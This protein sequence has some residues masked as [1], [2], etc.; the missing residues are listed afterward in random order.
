MANEITSVCAPS[1]GSLIGRIAPVG[2][3]APDGTYVLALGADRS[4]FVVDTWPAHRLGINGV[5]PTGFSGGE[6]LQVAVDRGSTQTITFQAA[7][8]TLALVVDRINATLTG[9][10]ASA[11]G[12]DGDELKIETNS[13]GLN[14]LLEI[15]GGTGVAQLGHLVTSGKGHGGVLPGDFFGFRQQIDLTTTT[16]LT[17]KM[18]MVQ[19]ANTGTGITFAFIASVG[20]QYILE[21]VPDPGETVDFSTR[22]INVAGFTGSQNVDFILEARAA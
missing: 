6:T 3:V 15:V 16:L 20:G 2:W 14:S 1:L 4:D 17:F 7:D 18:K 10:V 8:Q 21:V 5:Y 13:K 11:A 12:D 9:A 19:P 22:R